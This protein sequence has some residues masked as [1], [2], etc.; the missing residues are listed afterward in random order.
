MAQR[1]IQAIASA[2]NTVLV[3]ADAGLMRSEDGGET[4]QAA[5]LT[6]TEMHG[7]KV[8]LRDV[9][10]LASHK[11]PS[12]NVL[13]WFAATESGIFRRGPGDT[14]W[15]AV[16][17]WKLAGHPLALVCTS[18]RLYI[19]TTARV[20]VGQLVPFAAALTNLP[21]LPAGDVPIGMVA[22]AGNP[23]TVCIAGVSA[24]LIQGTDPPWIRQPPDNAE[25]DLVTCVARV[26]NSLFVGTANLGV[27]EFESD[28]YLADERPDCGLGDAIVLSLFVQDSDVSSLLAGTTQGVYRGTCAAAGQDLIIWKKIGTNLPQGVAVTQVHVTPTGLFA[29]T[30]FHG[31]WRLSHSAGDSGAWQLAEAAQWLAGQSLP[32]IGGSLASSVEFVAAVTGTESVTYLFPFQ[33][34]CAGELSVST[35]PPNQPVTLVRLR[36]N[37]TVVPLPG[38]A[39]ENGFYA[40]ETTGVFQGAVTIT[41]SIS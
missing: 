41:V 17:A 6:D 13:A 21:K 8:P 35:S 20:Q 22:K 9:V 27:R 1:G 38:Q 12:G 3:G 19:G 26:G 15:Q 40:V 29:V 30:P 32:G 2:G 14:L 7:Q 5:E 11:D 33:V 16:E 23:P 39:S 31:L 36:P 18:D 37:L 34:L 25:T 28:S 10:A 4:W 24:L